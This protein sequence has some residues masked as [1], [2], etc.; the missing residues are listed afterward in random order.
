MRI[1]FV[2]LHRNV[3]F[4]DDI[5]NILKGFPSIRKHRF[6]LDYLIGHKKDWAIFINPGDLHIYTLL[7]S[8]FSKWLLKIA[9]ILEC[10]VSLI[11]NGINPFAVKIFTD[12]GRLQD[13]DAVVIYIGVSRMDAKRVNDLKGQKFINMNHFATTAIKARAQWLSD[14]DFNSFIWEADISWK[15]DFFKK[16][17]G[18]YKQ[19]TLL[20]PFAFKNRFKRIKPFEERKNLA[21]ATGSIDYEWIKTESGKCFA[22][23]FQIDNGHPM[24]K[25]IFENTAELQGYVDSVITEFKPI[26]AYNTTSVPTSKHEIIV[27]KLKGYFSGIANLDGNYTKKYYSFN[28]VEK[29]NDYRMSIVPEE[30]IGVMAMGSIESM[31]CGCAFIGIDHYMYRD[32]GLVPGVHYITYD[33]TLEGLKKTIEYYQ[34]NTDKLKRIADAGYEYVK[35]HFNGDAVADKFYKGLSAIMIKFES[36]GS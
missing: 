12:H 32:I 3:N 21:V 22:D 28:M 11:L 6:F 34:K 9:Y 19:K 24:R 16:Y 5:G 14:V 20:L 1:V 23:F 29:Y 35:K 8:K 26:S 17:F 36:S 33:G 30:A 27:N 25:A 18:C 7:Q 10:Y 13:S 4:V 31:A 2:E 15:N